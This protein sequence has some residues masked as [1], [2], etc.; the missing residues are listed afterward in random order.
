[1][2]SLQKQIDEELKV[3]EDFLTRLVRSAIA[4]QIEL[5]K[6]SYV[7][8]HGPEWQQEGELEHTVQNAFFLKFGD[9]ISAE[10]GV[11]TVHYHF[12]GRVAKLLESMRLPPIIEVF[13]D[14]RKTRH[15]I[16][17]SD[18]KDLTYIKQGHIPYY[19]VRTEKD[20]KDLRCFFNELHKMYLFTMLKQ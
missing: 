11:A 5:F 9:V 8:G 17:I 7:I 6:D 4:K 13:I 1:M 14:S 12:V 16:L 3:L 20:L 18:T 19:F 15:P 10:R 2:P